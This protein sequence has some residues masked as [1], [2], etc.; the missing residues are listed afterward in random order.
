[1][2]KPQKNNPTLDILW[3]IWERKRKNSKCSQQIIQSKFDLNT[4]TAFK[5]TKFKGMEF[6]FDKVDTSKITGKTYLPIFIN[7]SFV[8]RLWR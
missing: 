3:K 2:V 1:M 8:R 5:K 7:E 6:V 4:E